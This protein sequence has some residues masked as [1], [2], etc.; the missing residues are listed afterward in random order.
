MSFDV[1]ANKSTKIQIWIN[2]Y[3][4]QKLVLQINTSVKTVNVNFA[5]LGIKSGYCH[6][7]EFQPFEDNTILE[8]NN[9]AFN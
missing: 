1:K 3:P 5:D 6:G 4:D 7:I 9:I 8:I 2:G